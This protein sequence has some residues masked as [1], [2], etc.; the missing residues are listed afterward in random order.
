MSKTAFYQPVERVKFPSTVKKT[1]SENKYWASF[2][3]FKNNKFHENIKFIRFGDQKPF[4][5]GVCSSYNLRLFHGN[6]LTS[7]K[8]FKFKSTPLC[9]SLRFDNKIIVAGNKNGCLN[10]INT[11][12]NKFTIMK[13]LKKHSNGINDVHF[14]PVS[15]SNVLTFSMDQSVKYWDIIEEK[16]L[17]SIDNAHND[18]IKSGCF[19]NHNNHNNFISGGYDHICKLWDIRNNYNDNSKCEMAFKHDYQI[20]QCISI[21]NSDIIAICG[22]PIVSLYSLRKGNKALSSLNYFRKSVTSLCVNKDKSR[23]LTGCLDNYVRIFDIGNVNNITLKHIYNAGSSVLNI[24]MSK[25]DTVIGIGTLKN[26]ILFKKRQNNNRNN[27][28]D[29]YKE[30]NDDNDPI[31]KMDID[32][33]NISKRPK[34]KILYGSKQWVER[35]KHITVPNNLNDNEM[36][37]FK[38]SKQLSTF[39]AFTDYNQIYTNISEK[40]MVVKFKQQKKF[41][42]YDTA[43]K[44]F[45][46]SDALDHAL[47]THDTMIVHSVLTNLWQRPDGLNI[48]LSGRNVNQLKPIL[49]YA[50]YTITH[51]HLTNTTIHVVSIIIDIYASVIGQNKDIDILLNTLLNT[52]NELILK[53]KIL[54]KLKGSIQC[55]LSSQDIINNPLSN[56]MLILKQKLN[57]IINKHKQE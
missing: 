50:I 23:L 36:K 16:T 35:G 27:F 25:D 4:N 54:I 48:A 57:E 34:K 43:L 17:F 18:F 19:I 41:K 11:T 55:I 9:C 53:Y 20:E 26:G 33:K 56:K 22:G 32:I 6:Q 12:T 39:D 29:Y 51:P 38:Q 42:A 10:V 2:K 49:E 15:S 44:Q 13:K 5:V 21:P 37:K 46:Y 52:I 28:D 30:L 3:N 7:M 8:T 1:T 40:F 45:R 47:K 24:G 31:N 14:N